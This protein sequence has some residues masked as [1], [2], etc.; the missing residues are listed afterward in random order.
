M[1]SVV[2]TRQKTLKL[3]YSDIPTFIDSNSVLIKVKASGIN[4]A[5]IMAKKGFYPDAPPLPTVVGYE[6]SGIVEKVGPAVSQTWIGKSVVAITVFKGYA[7]HVITSVDYITEIP[8]GLSFID[9]ASLPVVYLT[10]WVLIYIMGGGRSGQTLLIQNAG[11]GV[12]LAALD[13]A[14][15]LGMV[16]I[17]T[18]SKHKHKELLLRGL[19][20][21][22]DYRNE[23]VSQR[24]LEITG[25]KGCHLIIDP[26]GGKE[27]S[28]NF[29][30]LRKTGKLGVFGAS[31]LSDAADMNIF[32]RIFALLSFVLSIPKWSP[33]TLMDQNKAVFGVNLVL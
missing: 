16:T 30:L 10:A 7:T 4:F 27:W 32:S 13:I 20:H 28:N 8:L 3:E 11:G 24:V 26:I 6:V 2:T 29:K 12:G 5:D 19:D 17:G 9:A 23:N 25:G 22:I 33:L 18:A 31:T 14:K 1:I 15:H 21:A